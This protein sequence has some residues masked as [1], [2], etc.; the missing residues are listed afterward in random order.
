[1]PKGFCDVLTTYQIES[2]AYR[3][4]LLTYR[5][6]LLTYM[7]ALLTYKRRFVNLQSDDVG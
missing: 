4:A 2:S 7:A 3:A 1:M 6:T 5:A